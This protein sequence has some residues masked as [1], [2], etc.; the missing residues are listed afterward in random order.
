MSNMSGNFDNFTIGKRVSILPPVFVAS[1]MRI[2][3]RAGQE[4]LSARR[5]R[6]SGLAA[7]CV[8]VLTAAL[9]GGT[10]GAALER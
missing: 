7:M 4:R 5:L 3:K 6:V 2:Y 8:T 10:C 1:A 9:A